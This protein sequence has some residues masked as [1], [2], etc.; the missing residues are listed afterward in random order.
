MA[1]AS[2]RQLIGSAK[3]SGRL[4]CAKMPTILGFLSDA[5][6]APEVVKM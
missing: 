6:H 2:S 4:P 3:P 5:R 1:G